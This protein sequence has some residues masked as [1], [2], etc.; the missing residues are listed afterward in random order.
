M[1]ERQNLLKLGVWEGGHGY[2]PLSRF[3]LIDGKGR[4]IPHA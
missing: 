1:Y 4:N 3:Y 2:N